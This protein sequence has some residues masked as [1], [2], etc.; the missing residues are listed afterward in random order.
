MR[1]QVRRGAAAAPVRSSVVGAI[2]GIDG[3]GKTSTFTDAVALLARSAPTVGIGDVVISGSPTNPLTER[4]DI[5]L[6][7]SARAVGA[8]A[9]GLRRPNLY[10]D[11]KLLEFTERTFMRD[12]VLAHDPPAAL[13]TDGDPLVNVAAWAIARYSRGELTDEQRLYDVLHYLAGDRTIPLRELPYYLRQSWQL[14]L[15]NRLHLARFGFPDIVVLLRIAP[16][17][18]MARIRARGRPLQAHENV[19]F[20]SQ[21][22][23]A[24]ER[25]CDLLEARCGVCVIRLRVDE[26]VHADTVRAVAETVLD[27]RPRPKSGPFQA[28]TI[29]IIATT[30]S[31]SFEDQ[32][33]VGEIEPTFGGLTDR[34]VRV[35]LA[36]SHTAAERIAREIVAGGGRTI[37]SAGGAGT[38]NAVLEGCHIAGGLPADLRLAF[39]RKGSADLIGKVLRVPDELSAA[40]AAIVGGIAAGREVSADVLAVETREPD[41]TTQQRHMVG[42]GGLGVFGDI[43]RFTESRIIK[44][45]KGLLGTLFGDL[46]PFYVGLMLATVRWR[47]QRAFGRVEPWTLALDG[48]TLP[49][50]RWA[51]VIVLNGDLGNDFPLGRGRPLASGSFR[52]VV[53]RYHGMRTM[54][55]QI[56][57]CRTA[58]LLD[59]PDSYAAVVRDVETLVAEPA[60]APRPVMV[61][62]DG[63]R[64]MTRGSVRFSISG[65]VRLVEGG[66][67]SE[68]APSP[69]DASIDRGR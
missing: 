37:V 41:G 33:K 49:P 63:L 57:G 30:M 7:R 34:P 55:R 27:L 46:G 59:D 18:A 31:G 53:L 67:A 29:D 13:L 38:F 17:T 36:T 4:T 11:L 3:C 16:T 51:A 52:V 45:Y 9:K 2:V 56:K 39:L 32:R 20:L 54:L 62:V 50:E 66:P 58:A 22:A 26:A 65:R 5:P 44:L 12:Y 43:P 14:A 1:N 42:F 40:A 23:A 28:N 64:V 21:L 15:L 60:G 8:A 61:N 35:H 68:E 10:K 25:V 48:E 24:Y 69:A 19:T 47:I 6:S